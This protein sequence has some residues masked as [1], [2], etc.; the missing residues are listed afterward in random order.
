M[1]ILV[2]KGSK[3]ENP[4]VFLREYK[5]TCI[6]MGLIIVVK[7]IN[8]FPEFL[9][10]TA[11]QWFERQTK[12]LKGSWNDIIKALVKEFFVKKFFVK[13]V[14]QNLILELS[15]LKQG[16]LKSVRKYKEKTITLQNKLEGCLRA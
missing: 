5:R 6:S 11:S 14:Y 16:A 12:A 8:F 13:N 3:G 2:F 7:W 15:Q 9:K 10:S 4:E 1:V